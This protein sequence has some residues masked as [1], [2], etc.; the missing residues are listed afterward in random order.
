[1]KKLKSLVVL[2]T[3][4]II[5][6]AAGHGAGPIILIELFSIKTLLFEGEIAFNGGD[7]PTFSFNNS[8][9]NMIIYFVV[10]SFFGQVFFLTSYFKFLKLKLK[11]VFRFIGIISM[12]FGFFL[13]SKNIFNDGLAVFSFITGI[14]FLCFLIIEIKDFFVENS[15]HHH[16][17]L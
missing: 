4:F 17:N 15:K 1:M 11:T 16:I 13:I 8:Y 14:P 10:F 3:N 2:L 7:F 12:A 5:C 6:V 9:E